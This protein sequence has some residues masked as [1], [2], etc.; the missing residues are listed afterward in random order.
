MK[1]ARPKTEAAS[2]KPS[3]PDQ[4]VERT[5]MVRRHLNFGWWALLVFLSLGIALEGLHGFK[6]GAYLNPSQSTRR[7]M[8]TLAHAHGALL[9]MVNLGFAFSAGLYS[10]W[11]FRRRRLASSCLMGAS[12]LLPGG[13]FFGGLQFRGGDPGLAIFLVPVGA[14]LLLTSVFLTALAAKRDRSSTSPAERVGDSVT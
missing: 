11:D 10:T 13:F 8:W 14:A 1:N 12:V 7:L 6:V 9:A 2:R 3:L 4:E 5:S